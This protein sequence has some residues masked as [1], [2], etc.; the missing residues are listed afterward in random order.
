[1]K[2]QTFHK[3]GKW[4][5]YLLLTLCISGEAFSQNTNANK[6]AEIRQQMATIR[7]S[8]NW[9]NPAEAQ[10]ANGQIKVLMNQLIKATSGAA[11]TK[12]NTNAN[13]ATNGDGSING[14]NDDSDSDAAKMSELQME[15]AKHKMDVYNQIWE[16]GMAGKSAPVL[17]AKQ[18]R[19]D[20]VREFKEDESPLGAS[21]EYMEEKTI[22][23]IDMSLPNAPLL[24]DQ[25][26]NYKSIKTL[27]VT[28][29]KNGAIADLNNIFTKAANY[30]LEQLYIINFK[31]F[32][33]SIPEK[34]SNFIHL[35]MLAL[36]NNQ[37]DKLPQSI[38]SLTSLKELYLDMN[39]IQSLE[40]VNALYQ[41][42]SL[43]IAKTKIPESEI[44]RFKELHK[45][46]KILE[47]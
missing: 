34:I 41:L 20:I 13:S 30:P 38:S 23:V 35:K 43:G 8:T 18:L 5:F 9:D 26:E 47:K 46:C 7:Q 24:I 32:V 45:N 25:M 29:G 2:R 37:I 6:A 28:G 40:P 3:I 1:M 15:M 10:K 17:L 42:H 21:P 16:A 4:L 12:P 11:N 44:N 39:P 22:L 33:R 36:F 31:W 14:G 19:E 27:V